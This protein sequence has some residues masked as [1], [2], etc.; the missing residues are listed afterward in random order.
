[1]RALD[2]QQAVLVFLG[3]RL[4]TVSAG[5]AK[6][7]RYEYLQRGELRTQKLGQHGNLVPSLWR[8]LQEQGALRERKQSA[9]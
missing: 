4:L 9:N 6:P 8:L 5:N 3:N 1:M 7:P 2:E